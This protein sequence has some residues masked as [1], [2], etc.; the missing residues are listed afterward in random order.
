MSVILM[1]PLSSPESGDVRLV[2]GGSRCA[3]RVELFHQGEWRYLSDIWT[4]NDAAVI[5]R[6]LDCGSA[7]SMRQVFVG[8]I[9]IY[10]INGLISF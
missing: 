10:R 1:I 7:G 6:Q 3:G 2:G 9:F 5:C 4:L 8:K